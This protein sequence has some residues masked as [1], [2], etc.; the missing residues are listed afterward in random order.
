MSATEEKTDE[1]VG[2]SIEE[3]ADDEPAQK[4]LPG[5]APALSLSAGGEAPTSS[6]IKL[7]GGSL[8]LE[9]QFAK[10]E[11]VSVW[12]EIRVSEVQ[13][14]DKLDVHGNVSGTE[15]R[16]VGRMTSVQRS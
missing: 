4:P 10:G 11:T 8:T 14:V 3:A 7:R 16:H 1:Q 12:V 15:R 9:G 5:T 13:F 2:R 6:S